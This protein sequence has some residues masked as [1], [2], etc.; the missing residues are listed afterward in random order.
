LDNT[1][2]LREKDTYF[3]HPERFAAGWCFAEGLWRSLTPG[4]GG[5]VATLKLYSEA[6]SMTRFSIQEQVCR[7]RPKF[8]S[9]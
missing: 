4:K 6:N 3:A 1:L 7:H 2:V 8:Q 9:H 5:K